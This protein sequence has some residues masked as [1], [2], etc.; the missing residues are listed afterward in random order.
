MM[1]AFLAI[2]IP[3]HT[4]LKVDDFIQEQSKKDLPVKWVRFE[5]LHV[6]LKFLGEIDDRKKAEIIPAIKEIAEMYKPFK[7]DLEGVGCFPGTKNPRV[8]WIGVKQGAEQLRRLVLQ[9][10]ERLTRFGFKREKRYHAHLT[11]GR[12]KKFCKVD[13]ILSK[14]ITTEA[15]SINAITLFRST[16]KPE[17]PIYE[18]LKKFKLGYDTLDY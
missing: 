18:E 6:T 11:I 16:L 9:L 13:D 15:F 2:E 5:N 3:E 4:R 14:N 10:E 7:I 1:R 12:I 17:G 8:L